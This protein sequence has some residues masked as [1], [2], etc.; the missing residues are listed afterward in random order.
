MAINKTAG[1]RGG[2]KG[3][4]LSYALAVLLDRGGANSLASVHY[5]TLGSLVARGW[6]E[7]RPHPEMG[8]GAVR[9]HLTAAGRAVAEASPAVRGWLVGWRKHRRENG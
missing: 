3:A 8:P 2:I 7:R 6:I 9:Y 1:I 4:P 5:H